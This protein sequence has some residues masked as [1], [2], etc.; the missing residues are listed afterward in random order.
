MRISINIENWVKIVPARAEI[1]G[2]ICRFL[3]S[4][5]PTCCKYF[6]FSPRYLNYMVNL[7]TTHHCASRPV[8]NEELGPQKETFSPLR[9]LAIAKADP[10]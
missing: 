5:L 8:A 2:G 3:S 7:T 4:S 1:F 10:F 6:N 9:R